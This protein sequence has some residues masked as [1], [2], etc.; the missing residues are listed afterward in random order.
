[1]NETA[2]H[3]QETSQ[4]E[5][6][7]SISELAEES[8]Y[9]VK[10][11]YNHLHEIDLGFEIRSPGRPTKEKTAKGQIIKTLRENGP[12]YIA[13]ITRSVEVNIDTTTK[14]VK[15]L[16]EEGRVQSFNP[17]FSPYTKYKLPE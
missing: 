17:D 7:N 8:Q 13:E 16:C 4:Q 11:I 14:Y 9:T 12:L 2:E 3:I 10:T 6:V 15:E 1:M 5:N